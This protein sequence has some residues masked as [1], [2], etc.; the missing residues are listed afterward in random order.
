[1]PRRYG[2]HGVNREKGAKNPGFTLKKTFK[3]GKKSHDRG[4][5]P[6]LCWSPLRIPAACA[7][8]VHNL[9]AGKDRK[10]RFIYEE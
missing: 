5:N 9:T 4:E 2:Q 7:A 6:P 10:G 1:V 8:A 3:T